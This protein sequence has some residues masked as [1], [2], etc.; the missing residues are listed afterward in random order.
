MITIR[1]LPI[2]RFV[3]FVFNFSESKNSESITEADFVTGLRL[4][5]LINESW[6]ARL[7]V[8]V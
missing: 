8:K 6:S 2:F 3:L 1:F 4:K 5:F 7:T